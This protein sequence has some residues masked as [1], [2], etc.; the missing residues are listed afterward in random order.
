MDADWDAIVS[1]LRGEMEEYGELLSL[2]NDQQN[3]V[4]RRDADALLAI[5]D[6]VNAQ[7]AVAK[8]RGHER[9]KTVRLLVSRVAGKDSGSL[10]AI[11]HH[12]PEAARSLIEALVDEVNSLIRRAQRRARQNQMLI[13]RSIE[14]SQ[15]LIERLSPAAVS[16]TYSRQ[17]Q[18]KVTTASVATK[19]LA[20][21]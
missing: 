19:C 14:V 2:F 3:A 20:K 16:K 11:I 1:L 15:Q 9:D 5:T 4:L 17:G 8:Q 10:R 18:L 21:S 13:A 7:L 6:D 12:A